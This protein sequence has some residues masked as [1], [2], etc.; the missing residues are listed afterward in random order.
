MQSAVVFSL[1]ATSQAFQLTGSRKAGPAAS[2][3]MAEEPWFPNS[4]A[5]SGVKFA[6]LK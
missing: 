2:L 4:V 5:T 1:L 3:R 6:A